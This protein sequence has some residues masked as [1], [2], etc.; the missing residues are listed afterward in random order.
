MEECQSLQSIRVVG[1]TRVRDVGQRAHCLVDVRH[2]TRLVEPVCELLA[3]P[4]Q[5]LDAPGVPVGSLGVLV[6]LMTQ[7]RSARLC[8]SPQHVEQALQPGQ[9]VRAACRG[10]ATG[11]SNHSTG[12]DTTYAED[13]NTGY[14]GNGPQVMATLRN[15]AI[16][17]LHLAGITDITRTLQRITRDRTRALLFLPL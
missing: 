15:I 7:S 11:A 16:S 6:T 3:K 1:G 8:V 2:G 17:V 9:A 5:Q 12:C 10:S 13:G 4:G 14:S